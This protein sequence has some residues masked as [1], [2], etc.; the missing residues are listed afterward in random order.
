MTVS[1]QGTSTLILPSGATSYSVPVPAGSQATDM[2]LVVALN[3]G[4]STTLITPPTDGTWTSTTAYATGSTGATA[5]IQGHYKVLTAGAPSTYTFTSASTTAIAGFATYLLRK[6]TPAGWELVVNGINSD[7]SSPH[8]V[9]SLSLPRQGVAI[10]AAHGRASASGVTYTSPSSP[11]VQVFNQASTANGTPAIAGGYQ[12]YGSASTAGP[13]AFTSGAVIATAGINIGVSEAALTIKQN[14]AS[15][16]T[17]G[18]TVTTGNSGG[19]SGD[20]FDGV[21]IVNAGADLTFDNSQGGMAYKFDVSNLSAITLL[22]WNFNS[23]SYRRA[24][25]ADMYLDFYGSNVDFVQIRNS[26]GAAIVNLYVD[27]TGTLRL[28]EIGVGFVFTSGSGEIPLDSWF[29][30]EFDLNLSTSGSYDVR[31]YNDRYSTTADHTYS[32]SY[33]WTGFSPTTTQVWWGR[34][35]SASSTSRYWLDSLEI[36]DY[37]LPGPL[38]PP[39]Y[40]SPTPVD[41]A[42]TIGLNADVDASLHVTRHLATTIPLEIDVLADLRPD[43]LAMLDLA[44]NIDLNVDVSSALTI[45]TAFHLATSIDLNVDVAATLTSEMLL[46]MATTITPTIQFPLIR[47]EVDY[48]NF[49]VDLESPSDGSHTPS[50]TPV[51]S[52]T[53]TQQEPVYSLAKIE[54]QVS[55]DSEFTDPD[56]FEM[57]T[58]RVFGSI[59]KFPYPGDPLIDGNIYYWRARAINEDGTTDPWSEVEFF[60]VDLTVGDAAAYGHWGDVVDGDAIPHLWYITPTRIKAGDTVT[61]VGMGFGDRE[62]TAIIGTEQL[63]TINNEVIEATDDAYSDS[64]VID[65]VNDIANIEHDE[66]IALVTDD[67]PAPGGPIYVEVED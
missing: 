43:S 33:S 61:L 5:R 35:Y 32:G 39:S 63:T 30:V 49:M 2:V 53:V 36:N 23:A 64:R 48:P 58:D 31:I 18:T 46:H 17:N 44:T 34:F 14:D 66:L 1:V 67:I 62:A 57:E 19:A 29:R 7:T 56:T 52:F 11:F 45:G 26:N 12:V 40:P 54:V 3:T 37:G 15:G 42:T 41:L 59:E 22:K 27:G 38:A 10:V 6:S 8:T 60:V 16:G 50:P 9:P 51:L 55:E 47:L 4:S 65:T 24:G 25:R 20:A 28:T 13:F 21:D